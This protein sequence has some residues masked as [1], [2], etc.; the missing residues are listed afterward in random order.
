M[1]QPGIATIPNYGDLIKPT[2]EMAMP[3]GRRMGPN[4]GDIDA[5]FWGLGAYTGAFGMTT[6]AFRSAGIPGGS[7]VGARGFVDTGT[8]CE[9]VNNPSADPAPTRYDFFNSATQGGLMGGIGSD[10]VT[11][12]NAMGAIMGGFGG[13]ALRPCASVAMHTIAADGTSSIVAKHVAIDRICSLSNNLFAD[14]SVKTSLCSKSEAFSPQMP[15]DPLIK[16]YIGGISLLG[17]YILLSMLSKAK[18]L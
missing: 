7:V 9:D 15:D 12:A 5:D 10:M 8:T 3:S 16:A 4:S 18:A 17:L 11:M 14:P 2:S 6:A 1:Q 13:P